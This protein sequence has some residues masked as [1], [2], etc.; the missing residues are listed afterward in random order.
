MEKEEELIT[1]KAQMEYKNDRNPFKRALNSVITFD[2]G[3][4]SDSKFTIFH[5]EDVVFAVKMFQHYATQLL[6]IDD[7]VLENYPSY[8]NLYNLYVELEKSL[9]KI[10][11]HNTIPG[12]PNNVKGYK[13]DI[14][15]QR[16]LFFN[17]HLDLQL[18]LYGSDSFD[19][20]SATKSIYEVVVEKSNEIET[21]RLQIQE[22]Y[23]EVNRT[24]NKED[25]SRFSTDY[26]K[27]AEQYNNRAT[28]WLISTGALMI[29]T[30]IILLG[31]TPIIPR[32]S[33][34]LLVI[35]LL[36]N[37]ILTLTILISATL[38]CGKIYKV[39]QN[40][41][42]IFHH[43]ANTLATFTEFVNS[44]QNQDIK[45][46]VLHETTRTIFNI[47]ET[48]LIG[49]DNLPVQSFSN[50]VEVAKSAVGKKS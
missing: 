43:K 48:G 25:V 34:T 36:S 12:D 27:S 8:Q 16:D 19:Y 22:I 23:A 32:N 11:N 13:R 20:E 45:D 37:K 17:D 30:L 7:A 4:L 6:R 39:N 28:K 49:S 9:S 29:L 42:V 40:L 44:T 5:Y 21:M 3:I 41:S 2:L 50:L 35:K 31:D 15:G 47:P 24:K 18:F 38:W 14:I 33:D 46:Q 26:A 10:I 1:S